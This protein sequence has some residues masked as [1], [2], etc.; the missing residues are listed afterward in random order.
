MFVA[1]V[2]F[3]VNNIVPAAVAAVVL[4]DIRFLNHHIDHTFADRQRCFDGVSQTNA[5]TILKHQPIDHR[6]DV[7]F[8][9]LVQFRRRFGVVNFIVHTHTDKSLPLDAS[10]DFF[11]FTFLAA[12]DRGAYLDTR[13]F[14]IGQDRIDDLRGVLAAD[15][16]AADPTVRRTGAGKQQAAVIV[17]LGCGRHRRARITGCA[18]LFDSDGGGESFDMLDVRLLHLFEKLSGIGTERLDIFA[19]A[20]GVDRVKCQRTLARTAQTGHHHELIPRDLDIDILQVVFTR[21]CDADHFRLTHKLT[22]VSNTL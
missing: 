11:V 15:D 3:A 18:A 4:L 6:G 1:G 17:N 9:I 22:C 2:F 14:G 16:F 10:K 7:V 19:L 8:F 21:P 13:T 5:N 12:D 20:F